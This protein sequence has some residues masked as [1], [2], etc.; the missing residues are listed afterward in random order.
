MENALPEKN[1]QVKEVID[2]SNP[3]SVNEYLEREFPD[4]IPNDLERFKGRLH[5]Y[6]LAASRMLK[7]KQEQKRQQRIEQRSRMWTYEEMKEAA[8]VTGQS[9]GLSEGFEFTIDQ[10]NQEVFHLLCLYFTN[11]PKFEDYSIGD[12]KYSLNK[13]I[14][15]QSAERGV[16]KSVMLKSFFQNKRACFGYKHTSELANIYSKYGYEKLDQFTKPLPTA[17]SAM[18]FYQPYAGM[19]Y[20]EL[21]GEEKA[22]FMG[23]PL[24][25]SQ[26]VINSL[27]D[28]SNAHRDKKFMFHCTSNCD[29]VEI[30]NVAGK[31]YRSRMAD[32]FNLIKMKG[33][34]RRKD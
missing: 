30:E 31:N 26:Y 16:G 15:L 2:Y 8:M 32:M 19:M 17:L 25:I 18:N 7:E 27:Y 9:I 20:D 22:N 10:D 1:F 5:S 33:K 14:W 28:F 29:G 34:D 6:S 4:V 23:N 11:D 12:V 13:G 24:N 3:D 21:F